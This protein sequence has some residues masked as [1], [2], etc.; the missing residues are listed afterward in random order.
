MSCTD[1]VTEQQGESIKREEQF[2]KREKAAEKA[3]LNAL[4][5]EPNNFE[6]LFALADHYIKRNLADNA[7]LIANTMI[8][9]FPE[10]KTGYDT[11]NYAND[12]KK[13]LNKSSV[14]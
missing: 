7:I 14:Q 9:L 5:L 6:F 10:N 13:R 1:E 4:T 12:M 8:K 2:Q 11:L 3:L